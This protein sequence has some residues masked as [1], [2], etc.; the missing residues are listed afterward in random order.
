ML[1]GHAAGFPDHARRGRPRVQRAG[2]HAIEPGLLRGGGRT[3]GQRDERGDEQSHEGN[4]ITFD[5]ADA[6]QA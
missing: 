4:R 2:I 6:K 3:C 5:P 1:D